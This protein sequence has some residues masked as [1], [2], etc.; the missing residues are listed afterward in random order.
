MAGRFEGRRVVVTG[1]SRGIGAAI[2][3]RMAAEGANIVLTARTLDQHESLEGSL[4]ATR[5]RLARYGT[6]VAIVVADLTDPIDRLRVIPEATRALGGHI[7]ILVNNAAASIQAPLTGFSVKRRNIMFEVN[8]NAPTDLAL[9][10]APAMVEAGEGWI[11]NLSSGSAKF[12]GGPSDPIEPSSP[13][14][15]AYGA[16]K[17][18]LN[19]ISNGLAMELYG[20]G[21][22]VNTVEPRAA[23]LSEGAAAIVGDRL[24]P[25][26]IESMEAMVEGTLVLCD[27]PPDITGRVTV[28]LDNIEEFGLE[29][30]NLDGSSRP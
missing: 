18:A 1:S 10:V 7:E 30:R 11:V 25:D 23:V 15:S 22:R 24:R 5:D 2:A 29:V 26:Q 8:V 16:S 28:S 4:N 14:I 3:E 27:C 20:T 12:W 21:V 17:A 9:A 6:T 19:R 13:N